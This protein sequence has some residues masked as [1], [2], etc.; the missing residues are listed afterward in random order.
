MPHPDLRACHAVAL[1]AA[2][3]GGRLLLA[4]FGRLQQSQVA[5]K[6]VSDYVTA[7]DHAAEREIIRW[8]RRRFPQHGIRA[9]ESGRRMR[10]SVY[11][12]LV[13]PL[14]G[15]TNYIH[16]FPAWC[17]SVAMAREGR[18]L[19]GVIHDPLRRETFHAIQGQG[20]W[21]NHRRICV[22]GCRRLREGL[23]ATG[24]PFRIRGRL[25]P[26]L[27]SFRK[28]FLRSSGIRRAGS[29]A[30]D[31]AYTACGRV[32]GFWEMGLSAWDIAAGVVLIEEAGGRVSDFAGG[33]GHM[34]HG[35]IVAGNPAIHRQLVR[36]LKP[37]F[38]TGR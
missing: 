38:P 18:L 36:L 31:L 33:A 9:E 20:A 1:G 13:D 21:C 35:S 11:E 27:R 10:P 17:V 14:D 15:T 8:I 29:A 26:Y 34:A 30:L 28:I 2:E 7:L 16:Q 23:I 4:S 25:D 3:A 32:D 5:R 12:W 37:I 24:F 22:S 6:G 19:L